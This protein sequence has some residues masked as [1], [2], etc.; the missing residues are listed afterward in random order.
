MLSYRPVNTRLMFFMFS[1]WS[2]RPK[3]RYSVVYSVGVLSL[4]YLLLISRLVCT[5][6]IYD[7]FH[8]NQTSMCLDPRQK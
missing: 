2:L 7:K 5:G 3:N 6:R 4:L 8:V 1:H